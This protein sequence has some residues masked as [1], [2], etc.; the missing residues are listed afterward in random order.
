L[1][2]QVIDHVD[3]DTDVVAIKTSDRHKIEGH[4]DRLPPDGP[5]AMVVKTQSDGLGVGN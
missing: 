3:Q 5:S 1:V 4:T 2:D